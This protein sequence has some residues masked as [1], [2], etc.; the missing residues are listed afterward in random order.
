MDDR[1]VGSLHFQLDLSQPIYEQILHQMSTAVVR[2]KIALGE[3]IP[4]VRE[5]AQALRV[6]P[7]TVMHA[8]Q[9]MERHGLT[10]TH[11]GQGT[12]VTTSRE[13]VEQFRSELANTVID[14]FLEKM[15]S[16][17][18]SAQDIQA[19]IRERLGGGLQP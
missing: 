6:T 16:L 1:T 17:G 13:R 2:G 12:F 10:E 9:E 11:R 19:A 15:K 8:Y 5:M 7:N 3:K 14:E 4:S 18:F